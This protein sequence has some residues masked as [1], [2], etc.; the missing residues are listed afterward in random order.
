MTDKDNDISSSNAMEESTVE[1]SAEESAP[2]TENA[3]DKNTTE[4]KSTGEAESGATSNQTPATVTN[5]EQNKKDND[6]ATQ[7]AFQALPT[8]Q[9][10][11]QTVVPIL[12]QALSAVAKERPADPIDFVASYLCREKARF[13]PSTNSTA[14][15]ASTAGPAPTQ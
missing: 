5:A 2:K 14:D 13:V 10:L 6:E 9:Y 8:R 7:N 11:D 15:N 12:L 3:E 1:K 4:A